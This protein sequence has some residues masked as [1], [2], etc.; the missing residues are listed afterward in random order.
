MTRCYWCTRAALGVACE[1]CRDANGLE[2]EPTYMPEHDAVFQPSIT[3]AVAIVTL[4][5]RLAQSGILPIDFPP[6]EPEWF[7]L[8]EERFLL[9]LAPA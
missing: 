1:V 8:N 6:D 9:E 2:G 5:A 3:Y 7:A 4:R